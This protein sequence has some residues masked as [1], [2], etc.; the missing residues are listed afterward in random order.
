[1]IIIFSQESIAKQIN[2]NPEAG[3]EATINPRFSNFTV[4]LSLS[5]IIPFYFI[6]IKF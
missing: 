3:W 2:E 4:T 6:F 1:M 5:P